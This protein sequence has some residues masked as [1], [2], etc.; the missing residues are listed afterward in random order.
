MTIHTEAK[1]LAALRAATLTH[2][3]ETKQLKKLASLASLVEFAAGDI[4]YHEG[5]PGQAV[6]LVR[7]GKVVIEIE[8]PTQEIAVVNTVEVGEFFG[9]SSLFP[10]VDQ[11]NKR[12]RAIEPTWAFAFDANLLQEAWKTDHLLENAIIKCV[13]KITL[14]RLKESRQQLVNAF[15]TK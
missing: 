13:A 11:G 1:A 10:S 3:L 15:A 8:S 9:W 2:D 14:D 12:A 7:A 5:Q 6:Y 4:I